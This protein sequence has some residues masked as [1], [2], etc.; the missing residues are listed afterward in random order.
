MQSVRRT[1][2]S[3]KARRKIAFLDSS[4]FWCLLVFLGLCLHLSCLCFWGHFASSASVTSPFCVSQK[5][6]LIA[7]G[8]TQIIQDE[9]L[10]RSCISKNSFLKQGQ[11]QSLWEL[12]CKPISL[13]P[14][15]NS[16]LFFYANLSPPPKVRCEPV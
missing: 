16:N 7:S 8:L 4:S 2:F 12:E 15:F 1:V 11:T 5:Q 9:H 13:G 10:S 14:P 3:L 6:M